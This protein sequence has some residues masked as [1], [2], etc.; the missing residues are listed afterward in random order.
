MAPGVHHASSAVRR[1]FRDNGIRVA[2]QSARD[3]IEQMERQM[4]LLAGLLS[5][6]GSISLVARASA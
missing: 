3:I 5:A 6:V 2:V 1:Y 4:Q